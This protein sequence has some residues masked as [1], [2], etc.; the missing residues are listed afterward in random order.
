MMKRCLMTAG[1]LIVLSVLAGCSQSETAGRETDPLETQTPPTE[2]A[3]P[4]EPSPPEDLENIPYQESDERMHRLDVHLPIDAE[5]PY[6]V[7]LA[8][9]GGHGDKREMT[10]LAEYFAER[11]FAVLTMNFRDMPLHSYPAPVEDAFCALGWI[12]ANAGTYGFDTSRIVALGFSSGAD[13]AS[14]LGVV[15]NPLHYLANCPYEL[16]ETNHVAAVVTFTG[17]F[18]LRAAA[19]LSAAHLDYYVRYVGASVEGNPA[20]WDEASVVSWVTG[21]APPFLLIHGMA[22]GNIPPILSEQFA[23]ELHQAG[24][25]AETYYVAGEDHMGIIR[26]E[27]AFSAAEAFLRSLL[28]I[29]T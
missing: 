10:P 4:P 6:P 15:D 7:I 16:P 17:V 24:V 25:V 18:N 26:S 13:L 12:Y 29:S 5:A 3:V 27:E 14:M 19:Q 23:E 1:A 21:E 9:H 11:G 22:D 20:L 8:I 2:T 28:N